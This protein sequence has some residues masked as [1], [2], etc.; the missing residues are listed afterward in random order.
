MVAV[1]QLRF[2]PVALCHATLK[3]E[4]VVELG[5]AAARSPPLGSDRCID[6]D[7]QGQVGSGC[8]TVDRG[9]KGPI[10]IDRLVGQR[11]QSVAIADDVH[12]GCQPGLDFTGQVIE[13]I[14]G[15][16]QRHGVGRQLFLALKNAPQR[17]ANRTARRFAGGVH[18][19]AAPLK[20]G[21]QPRGLRGGAGA[22]DSLQH[23]E[24]APCHIALRSGAA[25]VTLGFVQAAAFSP[26]PFGKY[27]LVKQIGKGGM[28]EVFLARQRGPQGFEKE[29][30]IKRILPKLAVDE[31][32]VRMFLDEARIAA[33]LS[34]PNIVQIFDLGEAA[35]RE[36]FIAME[37]VQGVD[38]QQIIDAGTQL[39]QCMPL[40]IAI[41]IVSNVAEGLGHAH[42]AVDGRGQPLGLVHRDISPSNILVS[43]DGIA[44]LCDFG[45]AKAMAGQRATQTGTIKGKVPYMSPEQLQAHP[46]DARSDLFSLG[47]VL[48]QLTC[49]KMP[50]G[51]ESPVQRALQTLQHE[52]CPPSLL[53]DDYPPSL[54]AVATRA[55]S[56][57]P[58]DRFLARP[59]HSQV[60][61]PVDDEC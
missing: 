43:F 7:K 13:T 17:D 23:N 56:K 8:A 5:R 59:V 60:R 37:Y 33:P 58:E 21:T 49:G 61:R 38:L 9:N 14:G 25:P 26:Q 51:G 55:L 30:V 36:Y 35:P 10:D 1:L 54:A 3:L 12:A 46:L 39:G 4:R 32:F 18:R 34:H 57:R 24:M 27:L 20:V 29:C 41:R 40:P 53:V 15:K 11:R 19:V 22:V 16:Q 45:I 31:Q 44:K 52:P 28:A 42:R 48:Y 47:V 2:A 50:F 6:V